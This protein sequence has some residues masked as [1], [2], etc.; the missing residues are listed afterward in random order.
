VTKSVAE[1]VRQSEITELL[2]RYPDL[3][4]VPTGSTTVRIEGTLRFSAS[5]KRTEVIEDAYEVRIEA[6]EDF[7][8]Q[9]ALAWEIGGR[10]P[11]DYHKLTNGALCLGSRVGLRLQM[12]GS[13]SL[14]RFVERCLV[15]YLYG[16]SYFVKHG[17]PP[18]GELAH[19][20]LGSLQDLAGLLGIDDLGLA[21]HYCGLGA[22]K[23]R[24]ANKQPCP[25]GSGRRLGRCHARKVNALRKRVG[26][27]ALASEMSAIASALRDQQSRGK[28]LEIAGR[29]KAAAAKP[30]LF[31]IIPEMRSSRVLPPWVLPQGLPPLLRQPA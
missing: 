5:S 20:E 14:L 18:F 1:R 6:P 9:M 28:R 24:R 4:L 15:P 27:A 21:F 31:E 29:P 26:R 30:T 12:R 7:P 22:L 19:G 13:P 25:C 23:R 11:S 16:Y 10:I 8:T 3:R 2:E 17:S